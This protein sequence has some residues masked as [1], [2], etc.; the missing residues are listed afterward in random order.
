MLMKV[1]EMMFFF[2]NMQQTCILS[3]PMVIITV[4]TLVW[5]MLRG[6][7]GAIQKRISW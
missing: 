3:V 7:A 2:H 1:I 4:S 5:T 6:E